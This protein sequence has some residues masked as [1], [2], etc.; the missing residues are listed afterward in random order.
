MMTHTILIP[1]QAKLSLLTVSNELYLRKTGIQNNEYLLSLVI[2]TLCI[3]NRK[4]PPKTD[5]KVITESKRK[6]DS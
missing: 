3:F 1:S 6:L 2:R 4:N 5:L